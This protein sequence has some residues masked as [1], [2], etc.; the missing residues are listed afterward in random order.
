VNV[1]PTKTEVKF[2]HERRVYAAVQRAIRAAVL[3]TTEAPA[4]SG[5][6]GKTA[7]S[8]MSGPAPLLKPY[9]PPSEA[10]PLWSRDELNPRRLAGLRKSCG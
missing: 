9:A 2:V 10:A 8:P 7:P 1:S 3:N 6:F 4:V 5:A